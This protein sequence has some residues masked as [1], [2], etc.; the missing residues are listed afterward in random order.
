LKIFITL[1]EIKFLNVTNLTTGTH[2]LSATYDGST[3][4]TG[5]L[6]TTSNVVNQTIITDTPGVFYVPTNQFDTIYKNVTTNTSVVYVTRN[7]SSTSTPILRYYGFSDVLIGTF[8]PPYST[9][10]IP[11]SRLSNG[12][13]YYT[14]QTSILP[15]QMFY[16][17]ITSTGSPTVVKP[18]DVGIVLQTD[19]NGECIIGNYETY[20][21]SL[22]YRFSIRLVYRSEVLINPNNPTIQPNA[23]FTYRGRTASTANLGV[24]AYPGGPEYWGDKFSFPAD[25]LIVRVEWPSFGSVTTSPQPLI[26]RSTPN[27]KFR[28][29]RIEPYIFT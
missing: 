29:S 8:N 17:R 12:V 23:T 20:F 27:T 26:F 13:S 9:S 18:I 22:S 15:H 4:T 6:F 7:Y 14:T 3:G 11:M 16:T 25:G 2:Q 28:F 19:S 1:N 24:T 21:T 10:N 5:F